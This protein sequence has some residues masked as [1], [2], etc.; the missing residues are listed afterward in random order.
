MNN[1]T[2]ECKKCGSEIYPRVK[3]S[4]L[5]APYIKCQICKTR[6]LLTKDVLKVINKAKLNKE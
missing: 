2:I 5:G 4:L 6:H 3:Y 1:I